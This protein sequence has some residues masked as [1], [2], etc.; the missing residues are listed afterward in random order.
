MESALSNSFILIP[1]WDLY[2][3]EAYI[4]LALVMATLAEAVTRHMT[5]YCTICNSS[6]NEMYRATS[7][8]QYIAKDMDLNFV[9]CAYKVT[10]NAN[11][12]GGSPC[13]S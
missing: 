13:L 2:G 7:H 10:E 8:T 9:Y 3:R 6:T 1:G 12:T 4:L 5:I 11:A